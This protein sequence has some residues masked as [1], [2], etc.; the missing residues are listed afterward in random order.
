M[1]DEITLRER[2]KQTTREALRLAALRLAVERGWEQV[3]VED[4]AAEAGVSTR[5][6]SNYFA[7]KDEALLATAHHRAAR[8]KAALLARPPRE[9]LW[10][11]VI[12]AVIEGFTGDDLRQLAN[13]RP[14]PALATEQLK[15]FPVVERVL[16]EGIAQRIG[17]DA[18]QDIFPHLVA[19]LVVTTVR[20]AAEHQERSGFDG[21]ALPMLRR[22]LEQVA[23]GL[24]PAADG[25]QR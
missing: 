18:E 15:V 16:A 2:K 17:A 24:R 19:G 20:I 8:V 1:S 5:T 9:P 10:D 3:R 11:A 21:P 12:S 22:A 4:I 6:F 7:T 25:D 13:V 14:T 23:A